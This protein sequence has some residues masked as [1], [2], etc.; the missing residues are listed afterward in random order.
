MTAE[1][2]GIFSVPEA[3]SAYYNSAVVSPTNVVGNILKHAL[4]H[5][6]YKFLTKWL[7]FLVKQSKWEPMGTFLLDESTIN[8]TLMKYANENREPLNLENTKG[9]SR[10]NPFSVLTPTK[11]TRVTDSKST[12]ETRYSIHQ[13]RGEWG[14]K[15]VHLDLIRRDRKQQNLHSERARDHSETF[16]RRTRRRTPTPRFVS[17]TTCHGSRHNRCQECVAN[18]WSTPSDIFSSCLFVSLTQTFSEV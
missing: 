17:G 5:W 3:D 2:E 4:K 11:F 7:S 18:L 14:P 1:A 6:K 16:P 10:N 8:E 13:A 15:F 12:T 9:T